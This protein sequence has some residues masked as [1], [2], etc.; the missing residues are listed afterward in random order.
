MDR[1]IDFVAVEPENSVPILD[2]FLAVCSMVRL[3]YLAFHMHDYYISP[4]NFFVIVV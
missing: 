1:L 3:H 2:R 4:Y